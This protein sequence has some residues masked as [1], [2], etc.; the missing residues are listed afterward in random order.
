MADMS[1]QLLSTISVTAGLI[2]AAGTLM[3]GLAAYVF[4]KTYLRDRNF[5]HYDREKGRA[6]LS[7]MRESY[8]QRI[9]ELSKQLTA[10]ETRFRDVNHLLISSQNAQKEGI[11]SDKVPL[12]GFLQ[13]MGIRS[14]D[15]EIDK[16]LVFVL[17]PFGEEYLPTFRKI[18]EICNE[19]G[20]RCVRGDEEEASG[21]IL[22]H[23]LRTMVK[24][25]IIIANVSSR[26]PNV[27]YEL[28]IAHALGKPTILIAESMNR[29]PFDIAAKRVMIFS[30]LDQLRDVLLPALARALR[31]QN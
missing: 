2:S 12:T 5:S 31:E 6:E 26:N 28:G 7:E 29:V 13:S 24:A 11:S 8:E 10:T 22:A 20:L 14:V 19:V 30:S 9:G 21:D 23:I 3:L 16:G 27:F 1:V 17:T 25:R 15:I 4:L 18:A